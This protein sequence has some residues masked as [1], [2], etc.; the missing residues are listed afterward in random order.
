MAERKKVDCDYCGKE[1][2]RYKCKLRYEFHFCNRHCKAKFIGRK[3]SND[4][5]YKERQRQLI[6]IKGNKPPL[7]Q[8][9]NHWN[10]KG[11][12]SKQNRGED[13]KYCQWRKDVLAKYNFTCQE[14]EKRGGR[15]SAHH[16]IKWSESEEF[17]YDINNGICLCYSCHMKI[18]GLQRLQT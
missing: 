4:L 11:G 3:L 12:I 17:R 16:L 10:W 13:Y 5:E 1:F 14:C 15:L 7:H 8:G 9:E 18:H 6:K 2:E